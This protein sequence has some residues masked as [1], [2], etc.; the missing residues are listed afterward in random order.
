[1]RGRSRSNPIADRR[2]KA[3][4]RDPTVA[5]KRLWEALRSRQLA[6]TKFRRQAPIRSF[7]VDFVAPSA[8]L[9]IEI[10]G[11]QHATESERDAARTRALEKEGYRVIRFWNNDV[12]DNLDGVL[13][14]I[15][16]RLR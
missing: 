15:I 6:G 7:I 14:T 10:D 2:A 1:V 11:G 8:R 13:Q 5:E 12:I 9:I 3:M 4:R 16:D